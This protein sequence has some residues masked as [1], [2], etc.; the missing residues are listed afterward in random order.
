MDGLRLHPINLYTASHH[1]EQSNFILED[2]NT[3]QQGSNF[4]DDVHDPDVVHPDK[5]IKASCVF[6]KL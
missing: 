6:N 3:A 2:S 1:N 5:H 4:E